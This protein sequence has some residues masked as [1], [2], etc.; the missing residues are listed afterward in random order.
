MS[1]LRPPANSTNGMW[2]RQLTGSCVLVLMIGAS[3]VGAQS[4]CPLSFVDQTGALGIDFVHV[5]GA[6]GEK[7]LPETMGAGAAWLDFDGDG[8]MDLYLVQSGEFPPVRERSATEQAS[9]RLYRNLGPDASGQ[10]RF[11]DVTVRAGIDLHGYGQG[12]LA[13]DFDGDRD[14]DLVVS[15]FSGED[16]VGEVLLENR[17]GVFNARDLTDKEVSRLWGSSMTAGDV[18]GDGDLDLYVARYLEFDPKTGGSCGSENVEYCDPSQFAGQRDQLWRNLL[19]DG[20][21]GF[22][23]DA[24]AMGFQLPPG[25]L[26]GKGLGTLLVDVTGDR[27]LDLY[28]ANDITPNHLFIRDGQGFRD[29]SLLSGAAVNAA[30]RAEAGMGLAVIDD[31]RDGDPDLLVTNFDVETNTLYRNEGDGFFADQAIESGFGLPSFNDLGFGLLAEDFDLDGWVDTY[32]ANGHIFEQPKRRNVAYRQADKLLRGSE[33]GFVAATC[34]VTSAPRVSRGAASADYDLDGDLDLVVTHVDDAPGVLETRL[35][36]RARWLA[37]DLLG[38]GVNSEAI[39]AVVTVAGAGRRWVVAG[40]SYLSSSS[41]Q[42]RFGLSKAA[43]SS[44]LEVA[45]PSGRTVVIRNPPSGKIL[46]VHEPAI[47][48][49]EAP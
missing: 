26:V 49:E 23:A 18:D 35:E 13:W 40:G 12:V 47:A 10:V 37:V 44:Q 15:H 6:T 39:G 2:S 1:I 28:V 3:H 31:D 42:L 8:W 32:T 19:N 45:W 43:E 7:Y 34:A 22:R 46:R 48:R 24:A 20:G 36:Q 38:R 21:G 14:Q 9:D 29:D 33:S 16:S 30:G 25:E 11:E 27:L 17:G 41:R 4:A 5:S